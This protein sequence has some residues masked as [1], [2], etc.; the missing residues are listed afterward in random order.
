[1]ST[2]K[3]NWKHEAAPLTADDQA[4]LRA[5]T[6]HFAKRLAAARK[7]ADANV[8]TLLNAFFENN[9]RHKASKPPF[10]HHGQAPW[11]GDSH[12]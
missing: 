4:H 1:M 7:K 5:H 6:K 12:F 8:G 11:E 9:H 10:Q 2:Y 3:R